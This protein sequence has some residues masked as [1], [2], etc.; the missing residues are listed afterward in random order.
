LSIPEIAHREKVPRHYAQQILLKL[1]RA[2]IVKSLRGIQ[3]GFVLA[4]LPERIT[5]GEMLRVLEGVPFKDTCNHFN[6]KSD[7]GHLS[8]CSIRPVWQI[9]SQRL[10]ESLDQISLKQLLSDEKTVGHRLESELPVLNQPS[11]CSPRPAPLA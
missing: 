3:G 2:G 4:R 11:G 5:L 7:C 9:V 10:W 8:G 6:R 1:G